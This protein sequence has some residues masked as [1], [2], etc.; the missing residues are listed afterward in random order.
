MLMRDSN[1]FAQV[2]APL[3][4]STPTLSFVSG[5]ISNISAKVSY[6]LAQLGLIVSDASIVLRVRDRQEA[7]EWLDR[8]TDTLSPTSSSPTSFDRDELQESILSIA[9][10]QDFREHEL[11][12]REEAELRASL[13][14]PSASM[15]QS[16]DFDLPGAFGGVP[17]RTEDP[18]KGEHEVEE[19]ETTMLAG[20]IERILA[21][22]HV[23]VQRV[24]VRLVWAD[25]AREGG[26]GEALGKAVEEESELEVRIEEIEYLDRKSVV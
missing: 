3:L 8:S 9:V 20:L 10:A 11:S 21:R 14:L 13:H 17:S 16:S 23:R 25:D 12:E 7:G 22:L 18:V 5:T 26:G 1:Q 19:V 6:P 2:I 15:T 24:S 4:L